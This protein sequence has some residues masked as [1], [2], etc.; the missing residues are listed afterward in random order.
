MMRSVFIG[1]VCFL[2]GAIALAF[3]QATGLRPDQF[4]ALPWTWSAAQTFGQVQGKS[5]TQTGTTYTF[6]ATDCGTK[7]IFTS[8]SVVTATIPAS[9]TPA[10]GVTCNIGVLQYGSAKVFVNGSAVT[11]AT[12]LSAS[13]YTGTSSFAGSEIILELTTINSISTAVL[14]GNGS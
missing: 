12:L 3:G 9:I 10:A 14:L 1:I 8:A 5:T 4:V 13:G 11:P 2:L 6:A 7:V